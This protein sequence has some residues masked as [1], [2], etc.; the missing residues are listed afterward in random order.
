MKVFSS[1]AK[2]EKEKEQPPV[3]LA[4][5]LAAPPQ[6]E[7]RLTGIYGDVTEEKCSEAV[8]GL[9][10][11]HHTGQRSEPKDLDDPESELIKVY[12]PIDFIVST[13][14]GHASEMF[15][16]YDTMRSI[17][18]QS[19]ICTMGIGKVMSAGVL[20]L[21]A[22]TK[23]SRKIGSTCRVMIHGV[24]AGQQGYISDMQNEFSET[25]YIQKMYVAALA[26]E[27]NMEER[28]IKKL[29]NKKTNVYLD[30]EEAV[31]L[32]IADIIF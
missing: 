27:T 16:V 32:G 15:A 11:Y 6:P 25:K 12:E 20:L 17:R 31:K 13:H 30:A 21:A 5:L 3:D 9:L 28:Y 10:A 22:G 4:A 14:G 8:Y 24:M 29:M 26:K 1:E 2:Q 18:D 19:P 7:L 23:G